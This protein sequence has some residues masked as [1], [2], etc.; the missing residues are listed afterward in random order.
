MKALE[1][2]GVLNRI[3]SG[4][5][6]SLYEEESEFLFPV[7]SPWEE[8]GYRGISIETYQEL[9]AIKVTRGRYQN[10]I[11]FPIYV[12]G[13]LVGVDA[14]YLGNDKEDKVAKYLRN[15]DSSCKTNWLFPFDKVKAQKP[16]L[17]ILGEGLFHAINAFDKGFS[18]LCFFGVNNFS[19]NK[20]SMLLSLGAEEICYFPDTDKAGFQAMQRVCAALSQW[21]KV[22]IA[23][24]IP[25][26][27]TKIDLGDMSREEIDTAVR[28]RVKP[29]YTKCL[30]E[31]WQY[32]VVFGEK[33]K[34]WKCPFNSKGCCNNEAFKP[35]NQ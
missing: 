6:S 30:V 31:D 9:G 7:G 34:R 11:C 32:K 21:F 10:R 3:G 29:V 8:D 13:E 20:V 4:K 28:T 25:Y 5:Q 27:G 26:V 16:S 23:N 17:V 19:N 2:K 24:I 33:C 12:N 35:D 18:G 1:I 22:S 15:K 14:R